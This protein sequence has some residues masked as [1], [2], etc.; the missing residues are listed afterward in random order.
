M[1]GDTGSGKTTQIPQYLFE[2][3]FASD[4]GIIGVTQPRYT[5]YMFLYRKREVL[6]M[7][8]F[9]VLS[10]LLDLGAD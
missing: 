5:A 2:A 3:G 7:W 9:K 4:T 6:T 10:N 1:V 8:N